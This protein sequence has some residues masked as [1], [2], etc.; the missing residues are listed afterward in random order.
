VRQYH[1][2]DTVGRRVKRNSTSFVLRGAALGAMCALLA[3]A[4]PACNNN[5]GFGGF[6]GNTPNTTPQILF[7]VLGTVGTPFTLLISDA[8]SS[9]TL[10]GNVP[11][12]V[13]IVNNQ[14]PA[15]M[16]ATKLSND[17]N[18]LSLQITKGFNI[19]SLSSTSLPYGTASVQTSTS[20]SNTLPGSANPDLRIFV[21]GAFGERMQSLVED[22][23]VGFV[24]QTIAPTL[25][26]F[27]SPNGKIDGQF[28][29]KNN[30]GPITANI[31]SNGQLLVTKT[32]APLLVIRQP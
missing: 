23:S 1:W 17:N 3:T 22:Q 28:S 4:M 32:A 24:F 31:T 2:A 11:L 12:Q 9:W 27:D 18:L 14:L 7:K 20:G 21:S 10:Q 5:T 26:L 13:A 16:I 30:V 15:R 6:V 19:V 29:Q 25:F 8:R